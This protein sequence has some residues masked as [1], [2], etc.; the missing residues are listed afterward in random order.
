VG[1]RCVVRSW[2][3]GDQEALVRHGDSRAVWINLRDRFPHP[4]T[5]EAARE[6]LAFATGRAPQ[7]HFAIEVGGEA[8]GGI[9]LQLQEDVDRCSAEVGYWLGEAVWGRGIAAEALRAVTE[10]AFAALPLTRIFALP[11]ARNA[12]SVRVLEKAGYRREGLLR[13]S[14]IK[15]GQVLDQILYAVT[16]EEMRRGGG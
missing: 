15:E 7:T 1:E 9:G 16:D 13:R 4:Y 6:W 2:H 11:F 8:V 3:H 5:A 14:A 10:H 12:A